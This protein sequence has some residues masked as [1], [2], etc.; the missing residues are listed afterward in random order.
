M[1][2]FTQKCIDGGS[3]VIGPALMTSPIMT[4]LEDIKQS[5]FSDQADLECT[6]LAIEDDNWE[7]LSERE[8]KVI[9][10]LMANV[11]SDYITDMDSYIDAMSDSGVLLSVGYN[12]MVIPCAEEMHTLE[13]T[14]IKKY[15]SNTP[16]KAH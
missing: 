4:A 3:M 9:C 2:M 6:H 1:N 12:G 11:Y 5:R 8:R 13:D 14:F 7:N 15:E 16:S 10:A